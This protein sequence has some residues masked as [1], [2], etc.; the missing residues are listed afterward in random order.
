[1]GKLPEAEAIDV[2]GPEEEVEEVESVV[3]LHPVASPFLQ[4]RGQVCL[5]HLLR[6]RGTGNKSN[7]GVSTE[8]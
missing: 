6:L 3:I 2:G 7:S 4:K 1:M 5:P 8:P